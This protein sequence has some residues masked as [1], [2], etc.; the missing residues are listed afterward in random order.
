ML[1]APGFEDISLLCDDFD[2]EDWFLYCVPLFRLDVMTHPHVVEGL[3][4]DLVR[5]FHYVV[6]SFH[7]LVRLSHDLVRLF[8]LIAEEVTLCCCEVI[9]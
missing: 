6:R 9:S 7:D 3:L 4:H 8:H 1:L 2:C 5:S